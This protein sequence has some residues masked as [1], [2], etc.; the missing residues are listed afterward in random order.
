M[1]KLLLLIL[2]FAAFESIAQ[3]LSKEAKFGLVTVSSGSSDDA[4]YQ[5][6]GHT[7]LHLMD[8]V[9]GINECYD[10]GSFSFDQPGF[11][12]KFLRGTLPYK[13]AKYDFQPFI[14]HYKYKENRSASEQILNLSNKQ[15]ED[16]HQFLTNNYLPENREY[17][18]RFFYYNC[19]S[20]IR[21]I[22]QQVCK[23]SLQFSP[24]LHADSTYRQ[25]IDKYA[26]KKKP[27]MN[28][29]M[30]L[31]IGLPSDEKTKESGAM[32]LPDNL[33]VGF[34]S[35]TI[36][37][38]GLKEPFVLGKIQHT[39]VEPPSVSSSIFSPFVVFSM[40]FGLVAIYTFGQIKSGNKKLFFDKIFFSIL[41]IAGWFFL[42]LWFLTDHGVTEK[43]MNVI[44]AFPILFPFIFFVKKPSITKPL[45]WIYALLN[46]GLLLVW[47]FKPQGIP[48]AV[49]PIILAALIRV[50][51][52]LKNNHGFKTN[53]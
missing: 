15:K 49:I 13:M 12:V 6:W 51:F 17:K 35:A 21:D 30:S 26:S 42:G 24:T 46:I 36:V 38:G 14:D 10:Y 47:N 37:H 9:N 3:Q 40:L 20:R 34:D 31:A 5:I 48:L 33:S 7:V 18:Y 43:N 25:W 32:F 2:L 22:L 29:G 23:D 19:A 50:A 41:G 11:V 4:I 27:W 8:P 52:I 16:L 28:F 1:K 45:L 39:L 53:S 44:W